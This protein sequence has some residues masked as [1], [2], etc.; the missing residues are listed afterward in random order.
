MNSLRAVMAAGSG[1]GAAMG[2][3][4]VVEAARARAERNV[5]RNCIV[6]R[7]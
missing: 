5:V 6:E 3:A 4:V 7:Y 1:A 2:D